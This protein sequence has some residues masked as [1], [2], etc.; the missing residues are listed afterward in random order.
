MGFA[1]ETRLAVTREPLVGTAGVIA[2]AGGAS[3]AIFRGSAH[4]DAAWALL[5]FLSQPEEQRELY[6]LTG[7]LP[8]RKS[9]WSGSGP[10]AYPSAEAWWE[11]FM[12]GG[13]RAF[14]ESLPEAAQQ[15]FRE[16][17]MA[18]LESADRT[19]RFVALLATARL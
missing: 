11:W 16:R 18:R 6:R 8:A 2:R 7:D 4:R 10:G 9:G 1:L 13:A 14:V 5:E 12:S 17:G 15:E 3:L 19:R